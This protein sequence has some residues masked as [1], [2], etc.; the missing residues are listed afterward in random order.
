MLSP[1]QR[2]TKP[3]DPFV[4]MGNYER[5]NPDEAEAKAYGVDPS[6]LYYVK[7]HLSVGQ[8]IYLRGH[9]GRILS[10]GADETV[11]YWDGREDKPQTWSNVEI[12]RLVKNDE[13]L[14]Y[15]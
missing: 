3:E 8:Q 11:L 7:S 14:F 13:L 15:Y 1:K 5:V 4:P 6:R 2:A 9:Y 10:R 12:A